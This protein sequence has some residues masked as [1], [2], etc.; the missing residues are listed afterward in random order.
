VRATRERGVISCAVGA[1]RYPSNWMG[2]TMTRHRGRPAKTLRPRT[3]HGRPRRP[4]RAGPGTSKHAGPSADPPRHDR[5]ACP[6]SRRTV[7]HAAVMPWKRAVLPAPSAPLHFAPAV[8]EACYARPDPEGCHL[9]QRPIRVASWCATTNRRF[10]ALHYSRA[11]FR[12][13]GSAPQPMKLGKMSSQA[14][15]TTGRPD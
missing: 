9:G 6:R 12:D 3:R 7:R 10:A 8:R 13:T 1:T 15:A 14:R 2:E 11:A 5:L 4:R